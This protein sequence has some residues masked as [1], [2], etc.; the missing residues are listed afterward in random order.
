[1]TIA[2]AMLGMIVGALVTGI[3]VWAHHRHSTR[4]ERY[5]ASD[6]PEDGP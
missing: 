3:V 6:E 2:A 5:F 1:M 4:I